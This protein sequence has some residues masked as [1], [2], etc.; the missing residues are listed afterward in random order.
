M[1]STE[2]RRTH[3]LRND[4]S[5]TLWAQMALLLKKVAERLARG[6]VVP[7]DTFRQIRDL[8]QRFELLDSLDDREILNR[9]RQIQRVIDQTAGIGESESGQE[10]EREPHE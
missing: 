7:Q 1:T 2:V 3:V 8:V 6:E 5:T 4:L 10:P 9:L